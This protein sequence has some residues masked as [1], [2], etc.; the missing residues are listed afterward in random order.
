MKYIIKFFIVIIFI[1][2]LLFCQNRVKANQ[3]I[4]IP[5]PITL[6]A[7]NSSF[8]ETAR[9]I[10][11]LD[12][13]AS[14]KLNSITQTADYRSYRQ[15]IEKSWNGFLAVNINNIAKWRDVYLKGPYSSSVFYPFSGPDVLHPLLFYPEARD[16][17]MFGLERIGDIPDPSGKAQ[18]EILRCLP[19]IP[20][21]LNFALAHAFFVTTD[22]QQNIG[23][24]QFN[25]TAGIMMFFLR[26]GGFEVLQVKK[27]FIDAGGNIVQD[28]NFAYPLP[29]SG[30]EIIFRKEQKSHLKRVRYFQIDISNS[31]PRLPRFLAYFFKYPP[32]AT[33]IKSASYLMQT[34]AFSGI[35][36]AVLKNSNSIL[37]DDSGVPFR[38][39]ANGS[40]K[41][42]FHGRYHDPLPVFSRWKQPELE[43]QIM[44][45]STGPI[46]FAYGY[47]YGFGDMTYHLVQAESLFPMTA[48][49][50]KK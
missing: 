3:E 34:Q 49:Q 10:S 14:S 26:R 8:D 46:P 47:G 12:I 37:Q 17:L 41:L 7:Y 4:I 29:V 27:I 23:K 19:G 42:T 32:C 16:I 33:I 18:P 44:E 43:K 13:S 24:N 40:W 9:L 2:P 22:I 45:H 1:I 39:L 48:G 20:E 25:G 38:Y 30:V 31:S 15:M 6:D 11:G 5:D 50:A 36:N 28:I 35:S 21:V